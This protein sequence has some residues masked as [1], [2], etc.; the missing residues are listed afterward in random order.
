MDKTTSNVKFAF[1]F[2]GLSKKKNQIKPTRIKYIANEIYLVCSNDYIQMLKVVFDN[3]P[4]DKIIEN[5]SNED[6]IKILKENNIFNND[7][8]FTQSFTGLIKK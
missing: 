3:F 8:D 6:D 1:N 5:F 2:I 4:S 7:F